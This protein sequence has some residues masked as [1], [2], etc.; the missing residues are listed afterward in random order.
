[1]ILKCVVLFCKSVYKLRQEKCSLFKSP[2][3]KAKLEAWG[4]A[5][6][7]KD[8]VLQK[9]DSMIEEQFAPHFILKTRSAKIDV[10]V[11]M[12]R[13]RGAGLS[14][15]AVPSIFEGHICGR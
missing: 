6:P 13:K 2:D 10:S 4:R 7:C 1:M 14:K 3:E 8:R 15:D 9:T 5:I 12:S 11:L